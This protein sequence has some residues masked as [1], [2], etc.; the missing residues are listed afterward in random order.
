MAAALCRL[1]GL[2]GGWRAGPGCLGSVRRQCSAPWYQEHLKVTD[3]GAGRSSS[4]I[5]EGT[6]S[7]FKNPGV[8]TV[9]KLSK[10]SLCDL[11]AQNVVYMEGPLV[12]VNKPQGLPITGNPETLSLVS[13]LPELQQILQLKSD[14]HV[15]K[16]APK[17]SSG[18]VLLSSCYTTTKEFEDYYA[19]CRKSEQPVTTFCAITLGVPSPAQGE[20]KVALKQ[21]TIGD[22]ELVFPVMHPSKGSLERKEVKRTETLYKVV[23]SVEGCSLLQLQPLSVYRDQLLVHCTL[24]FCPILGDHT[25]SPRV[26]KVLGENIYVPVDLATP[27]TQRIEEK[28]LRKMHITEPQVHRIPLHLHLQQLLMP[29]SRSSTY[30]THLTAP[31][32]P[33]FQRTMKLLHL[34]MK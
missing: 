27:R 10:D 20:I 28:T 1:P 2:T 6:S 19:K 22:L 14:L 26:A 13:I 12:A 3:K 23:H 5:P 11:L 29:D 18:L 8:T 30:P 32:P 16:A 9:D 15:V 7:I 25:Y 33:F 34:K 17:E 4:R 21:E 31:P 24:K